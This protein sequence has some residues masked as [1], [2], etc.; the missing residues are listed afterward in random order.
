M[1]RSGSAKGHSG[2]LRAPAGLEL[3]SLFGAHWDFKVVGDRIY[4]V[5]GHNLV[6][7]EWSAEGLRA[8]G[9]SPV[10][11]G[12]AVG[13]DVEGDFAYV[14]VQ[15]ERDEEPTAD[16]RGGLFIF[17]VSSPTAP[18]LVADI[19]LATHSASGVIVDNA[20]AYVADGWTIGASIATQLAVVD[21]TDPTVP[22]T[23]GTTR[24]PIVHRQRMWLDRLQPNEQPH[25]LRL[26]SGQ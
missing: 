8:I 2:N 13:L 7:S 15:G 5:T 1:T 26:C 17:D 19:G 12:W 14:A 25:T 11:P 23:V 3:V 18:I 4:A 9:Q 22:V 16:I 24:M 20:I 10:L 6:V 21:V